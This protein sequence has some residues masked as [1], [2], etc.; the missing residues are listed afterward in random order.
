MVLD[1]VMIMLACIALSAVHPGFGFGRAGWAAASY[2]F[3]DKPEGGAEGRAEEA[4]GEEGAEKGGKVEVSEGSGM[5]RREV[6]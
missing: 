5:G 2:P 6:E 4:S 1:G 3:F